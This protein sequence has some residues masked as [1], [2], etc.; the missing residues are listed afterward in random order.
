M[1]NEKDLGKITNCGVFD[2]SS[3]IGYI[4]KKET[5]YRTIQ[6][7]ELELMISCDGMGIINGRTYPLQPNTLL[8]A[9][10]EQKRRSIFGFKCFFIHLALDESSPYYKR[11][12][13][14]PDYYSL[15]DSKRYID[16]FTDIIYYY[17]TKNLNTESDIVAAKLIELFYYLNSDRQYNEKYLSIAQTHNMAIP[18]TLDYINAHY[19][20][21]L[22][23]TALS[24]IAGYS[25]NY[26]QHVF[27]SV[28][29]VTPQ[30]YILSVRIKAAKHLLSNPALSLTD[31]TYLCGFSSQAYFNYVFKTQTNRTPLEY[32]KTLIHSYPI[33]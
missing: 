4:G 9:K 1:F 25:K 10:P 23:L 7:F 17:N 3:C 27:K 5:Q 8:F 20:E 24:A 30:Q 33:E 31:V 28:L 15:I 14:C 29:G 6:D 11:L 18:K 32:R 13:A 22:D 26:Y 12:L 16:L 19:E 2:S 21:K